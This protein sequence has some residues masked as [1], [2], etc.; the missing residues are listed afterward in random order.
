MYFSYR[1][2][3]GNSRYIDNSLIIELPDSYSFIDKYPRL[4]MV[5]NGFSISISYRNFH[6]SIYFSFPYIDESLTIELSI[7]ICLSITIDI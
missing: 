6:L 1:Y 4:G 3:V 2:Y 5:D 7:V